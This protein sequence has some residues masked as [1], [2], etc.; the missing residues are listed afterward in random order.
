MNN[1]VC[2]LSAILAVFVDGAFGASASKP[3]SKPAAAPGVPRDHAILSIYISGTMHIETNPASWPDPD[4]LLALFERATKAGRTPGRE[5]GMRWSIGADI[6]WL[7]GVPR[8]GELIRATEAMGVEWDVHAH[9]MADRPKCAETIRRLGGHPNAVASGLIASELDEMRSPIQNPDGSP[10][11]AEVVWGMVR[12]PGHGPG[13]DDNAAGLWRPKSSAEFT[14]HDPAGNLVAVGGG[15]RRLE[16]AEQ[17]AKE[18]AASTGG[19]PPLV[20]A[21]IMV[22]PRTLTVVGTQDGIEAIEA[23]ASRVAAM[24]VVQWATIRETAKAW[25]AAGG[26]PSRMEI[27]AASPTFL[28]P[29]AP[30]GPGK[31]P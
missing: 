14:T 25:L 12:R 16:E 2:L 22:S 17:L 7:E 27:E 26:V 15:S 21:T 4:Q 9:K 18:L 3:E 30:L 29:K 8:A 11:Q 1:T 5:T 19:R 13:A 31:A 28:G 23:W 10:W 24:P 6:G 20:S